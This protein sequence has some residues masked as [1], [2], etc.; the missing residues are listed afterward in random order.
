ML[1]IEHWCAHV[2]R[3]CPARSGSTQ[4]GFLRLCHAAAFNEVCGCRWGKKLPGELKQLVVQC[5]SPSAKD[6][7]GFAEIVPQLDAIL[8]RLPPDKKG[9]KGCT[10]M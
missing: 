8:A 6:R 5:W 3:R 1:L 4:W 2:A 10:I 7:P 9:K